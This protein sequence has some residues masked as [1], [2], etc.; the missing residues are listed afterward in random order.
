MPDFKAAARIRDPQLMKLLKHE[1]DECAITGVTAGLHLHH[2]IFKSHG[3]D[4]LR[5]NI[6]CVSDTLHT[7]YHAADPVA[8]RLLAEH[9]DV[10]RPDVACYIA[11]KLGSAVALLDWFERHGVSTEMPLRSGVTFRRDENG[12]LIAH[13]PKV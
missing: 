10:F 3:G 5:S 1:Y 11:E 9:I 4:D 6:V 13:I 12:H 2:V 7:R 8:R